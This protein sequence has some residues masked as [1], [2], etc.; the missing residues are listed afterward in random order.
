MFRRKKPSSSRTLKQVIIYLHSGKKEYENVK[1]LDIDYKSGMLGI[2]HNNRLI[3]YHLHHII[4][5]EIE[6]EEKGN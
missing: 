3:V 4:A 6:E 1:F 5:Y 2:E